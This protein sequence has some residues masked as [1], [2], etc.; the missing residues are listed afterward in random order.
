MIRTNDYFKALIRR[1]GKFNWILQSSKP[2]IWRKKNKKNIY[3]LSTSD[4]WLFRI[5]SILFC[6][7][8]NS[9]AMLDKQKTNGFLPFH[10]NRRFCTMLLA[11]CPSWSHS[12]AVQTNYFCTF[13]YAL[14]YKP[15]TSRRRRR[16][17][18]THKKLLQ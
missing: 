8:N 9:I 15:F 3:F 4:R 14:I 13:A 2:K 18:K 10:I 16:K 5:V 11:L 1:R 6:H 12:R 17:K 7:G